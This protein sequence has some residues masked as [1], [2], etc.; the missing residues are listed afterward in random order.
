[1]KK[2]IVLIVGVLVIAVVA[3]AALLFNGNNKEKSNNNSTNQTQNNTNNNVSGEENSNTEN[4]NSN[5]GER[6]LVLYFSMTGNTEAVANIIH[7]EVGG[8]IIKLET[9]SPYTTNY[10]DLLDIAQE[11]KNS[12]TRP[13]LETKINVENYDTIFLG[14]PIWWGDMP[15]AIYTFL[16]NYD[17]SGKTIVPFCTSGGSGLSGTP[18]NIQNE[19]ANATVT[20]GLS[21]YDDDSKE[22]QSNVSNW[23]NDIGF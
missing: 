8:D 7:D 21:I 16:D 14:Y 3:G 22:S 2:T 11:E 10:N 5:N 20:E 4:N 19:E 6:T 13:E 17:L 15:M 18:R 9:V 23:L 12:E 1:M